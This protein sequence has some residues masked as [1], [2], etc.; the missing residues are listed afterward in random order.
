MG[1]LVKV[2]R[3]EYLVDARSLS[4]VQ[5]LP[6][7]GREIADAVHRLRSADEAEQSPDK[8]EQSADKKEAGQ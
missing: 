3:A 7:T 6:F 4:K 5:G 8:A 1:Q 2:L